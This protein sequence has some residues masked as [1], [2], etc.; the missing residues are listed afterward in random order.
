MAAARRMANYWRKRKQVFKE[1]TFLPIYLSGNGALTSDDV[2]ALKTGYCVNLPRDQKNRSVIYIDT[3][4]RR[5]DSISSRRVIF[6]GLQCFMENETSRGT[7]T[8]TTTRPVDDE[9]KDSTTACGSSDS[10]DNGTGFTILMN[11]SSP[12]SAHF[13]KS[14][15]E[16]AQSLVQ[17][18]MPLKKLR[19]HIIYISPY[20]ST[21][22]SAPMPLFINTG[23]SGRRRPCC[24]PCIVIL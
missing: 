17:E 16:C 4:K 22:A 9:T 20:S 19:L 13:Q 21:I 24:K 10:D 1:R 6:F 15:L 11:V 5:A 12:H 3:S 23:E 7:K 18:C 2:Q 14:N 8:T